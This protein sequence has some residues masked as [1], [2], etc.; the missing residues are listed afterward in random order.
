MNFKKVGGSLDRES[1]KWI[2]DF[3]SVLKEDELIN[4]LEEFYDVALGDGIRG[5]AEFEDSIKFALAD[6]EEIENRI[7]LFN[8]K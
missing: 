4:V 6:H 2:H 1:K 7:Q 5:D 8:K 3:F